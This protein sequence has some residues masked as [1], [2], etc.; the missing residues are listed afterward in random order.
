MLPSWI[1]TIFRLGHPHPPIQAEHVMHYYLDRPVAQSKN[2]VPIYDGTFSVSRW[3]TKV[4]ICYRGRRHTFK[5]ETNES[6]TTQLKHPL[7]SFLPLEMSENNQISK[8]VLHI[9][10]LRSRSIFCHMKKY[11]FTFDFGFLGRLEQV[12][13][14]LW[15]FG[16]LLGFLHQLGEADFGLGRS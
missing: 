4:K 13:D 7:P 12:I 1:I 9:Y 16:V 10:I 3:D 14:G 8:E 15:V 2:I 5:D 6:F 11:F